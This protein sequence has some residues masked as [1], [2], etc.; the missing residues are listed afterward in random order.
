MRGI[1]QA[2]IWPKLRSWLGLRAIGIL[3]ILLLTPLIFAQQP[4]PVVVWTL[5]D[6]PAHSLRP[7]AEFSMAVR[8]VIRSGW[9]IYALEEPHGGPLETM[10]GL[11]ENR[12]LNLLHVDESQPA[13]FFD[14]AFGQR[15]LLFRNAAGFTLH[16]AI[17][18]SARTGAVPLQVTIR[19]QSCNDHVCLPP[20]TDTVPL[21][22]FVAR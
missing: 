21:Q 4:D 8:G 10:V 20:H 13:T 12:A 16:L 9:H 1:R 5:K 2:K 18:R 14:G 17:N 22:I 3:G 11:S 15:L 7:G 19:Y 6:V